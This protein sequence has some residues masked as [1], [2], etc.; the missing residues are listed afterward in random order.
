M[1][2]IEYLKPTHKNASEVLLRS[3][4]ENFC[5]HLTTEELEDNYKTIKNFT[6]K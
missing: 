1:R 4:Q 5:K 6:G 2:L 3:H